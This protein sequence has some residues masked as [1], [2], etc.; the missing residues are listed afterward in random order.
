[1]HVTNKIQ[2]NAHKDIQSSQERITR[3]TQNIQEFGDQFVES[4]GKL[5]GSAQLPVENQEI[6]LL[7]V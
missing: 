2:I 5:L 1:M 7:G 6:R 4:L 3:I